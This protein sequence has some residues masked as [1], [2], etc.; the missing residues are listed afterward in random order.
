[1][2]Q[3]LVLECTRVRLSSMP[4][5]DDVNCLSDD[6]NVASPKPQEH[7]SEAFHFPLHTHY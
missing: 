2:P 4:A 6:E 7:V 1:M 3:E 5:M